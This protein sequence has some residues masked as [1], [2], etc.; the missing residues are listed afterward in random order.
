MAS[1]TLLAGWNTVARK[2]PRRAVSYNT[3]GGTRL[4]THPI[5]TRPSVKRA[6][7]STDSTSSSASTG[8]RSVNLP[9][10]LPSH[11]E[12]SLDQFNSLSIDEKLE[13]I[14][15]CLQDVSKFNARLTT[16][17]G[18]IREIRGQ[19]D[20]N[21]DMAELLAYKSIDAEARQRRNNL[22]FW[23]IP[24][25][26]TEDCHE[27]IRTALTEHF[28][29]DSDA[30]CIQRAHRIGRIKQDRNRRG[31]LRHRPIIVAFL[32]YQDCELILSNAPRLKGTGI[33]VSRDYPQEL[34]KARRPLRAEMNDLKKQFPNAKISIQYPAKLIVDGRVHKDMFPRWREIMKRDRLNFE[35]D[36]GSSLGDEVHSPERGVFMESTTSLQ[37]PNVTKNIAPPATSVN[38]GVAT[39]QPSGIAM[40]P[41]PGSSIRAD[42]N[43]SLS[44]GVSLT[45]VNT[46]TGDGVSSGQEPDMPPDQQNTDLK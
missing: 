6:R 23:G 43:T 44:N 24:E 28:E 25:V 32:D 39:P 36:D 33:G 12:L 37:E 35:H 5:T 9:H 14:F 20:S 18:D 21:S 3:R 17:E 16:A 10:S 2:S 30:I 1:N 8:G 29:L 22:V 19:V 26:L 15:V 27:V 34:I 45:G 31:N 42:G 4:W 40:M 38:L 11:T 41:S 7:V 46:T 13:K